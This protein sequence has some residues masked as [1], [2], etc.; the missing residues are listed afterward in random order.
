MT[1]TPQSAPIALINVFSV[2]PADQQRLVDLLIRAT[3]S[4]VNSAAA[5][6]RRLCIAV[7]DGTKVTMF[8]Q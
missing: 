2:E 5:F 6:Y 4:T 3:D 8:A 7:F 1:Q